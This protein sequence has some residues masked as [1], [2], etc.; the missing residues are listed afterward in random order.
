MAKQQYLLQRFA[1]TSVGV[2]LTGLSAWYSWEFFH[3]LSAAIAAV[4]G[5]GTLHLAEACWHD[6]RRIRAL[7]FAALALLAVGISLVATLD[8]VAS[9]RDRKVQAR[10]SENL[11][12]TVA[13]RSIVDAKGELAEAEAESAR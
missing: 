1:A 5:A 11:G 9:E 13:E 10:Q 7:S 12:R 3:E 2:G 6:R 8:R 4:V